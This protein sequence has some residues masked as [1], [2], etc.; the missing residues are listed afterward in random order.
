MIVVKMK[1]HHQKIADKHGVSLEQIEKELAMGEKVE[2]AEHPL[3]KMG[4]H[5]TAM[6][7]LEDDPSYYTKLKA[8]GLADELEKGCKE[9]S[10][11]RILLKAKYLKRWKGKDGKWQYKYRDDSKGA[12]VDT[13]VEVIPAD[14]FDASS[15]FDRTDDPNASVES[16]L[17]NAP[18]ETLEK[19]KETETKLKTIT[20]TVENHRTSGEGAAAVYTPERMKLHTKIIEKMF[21]PDKI[22]SALPEA[23]KSPTFTML[24]GRGGCLSF[25][26]EYLTTDGGWKKMS[27]YVE[28]ERVLIFDSE[29]NTTKFEIPEKYINLPCDT[30]YHILSRGV[31]QMVSKEHTVLHTKKFNPEK[32]RTIKAIDL[33]EE[34]TRLAG[35]W[36]GMIPCSFKAPRNVEGIL[37][38]DD[39]LRLMVAVCADGNYALETTNRCRISLRKERKK[40]RL[41]MLLRR[42]GIDYKIYY[43][44]NRPTEDRYSFD[45]PENN[46]TLSSYWKASPEQLKIISEEVIQWDGWTDKYKAW[47]FTS[48]RKEDIDFVSYLFSTQGRR[49]SFYKDDREGTGWN[50]IWRVSAGVNPGSAGIRSGGDDT[51]IFVEPSVDGR[52]YCFTVSTGFF[53]TRRNDCICITGNSGKSW[54]NGK[55]YDPEKNVVL[56]SDEIKQQL[57]EYKGWNAFEVH[58]ES[59]DILEK[60]A[61]MA[62][63]YGLNIVIDATMKTTSSAVERVLDFKKAGY[64]I[65]A[66]YMHAP[67]QVSAERAVKRFTGP[68]GRYVPVGVVLSNVSNE[69]TFDAVKQY[70]S[71]WS[72]R[73]SSGNPP[74]KLV[75]KKNGG[76]LMMKAIEVDP[77]EKQDS[78]PYDEYDFGPVVDEKDYSPDLKEMIE[79]NRP[80]KVKK[81]ILIK[82]KY[83]KRWKNRGTGKWQYKYHTTGESTKKDKT[84]G[85][86]KGELFTIDMGSGPEKVIIAK[87]FK[88][89]PDKKGYQFVSVIRHTSGYPDKIALIESSRFDSAIVKKSIM[90]KARDYKEKLKRMMVRKQN[91]IACP[92]AEYDHKYKLQGK[93]SWHGLNIAIENK[94]GSYRRGK[95][96]NGQS[97]KTYMNYDYGR[98]GGSKATDNEG[99]DIYVGPDDTAEMVYVVHQQDPFTRVYDEDKAMVNFPSR[100]S[101]IEGFLSQ[102]DRPDFLGPISEFTIPDFK[103]ALKEKRGAALYRSP[104]TFRKSKII[105]RKK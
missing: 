58:E 87:D 33:V 64:K 76:I 100:E 78:D 52:K 99:V 68:T 3:D 37:L 77:E 89:D 38:T 50:P 56:D 93:M 5:K 34:N 61:A 71:I 91:N 72:F 4:A 31:D 75:S 12:R 85:F 105:V 42:C 45:A 88:P 15:Y 57:P 1:Q 59:S 41:E 60:A 17:L 24:G 11:S 6:H 92:P 40:E 27:E 84:K 39:E 13:S 23:G 36:D 7:H 26:H 8:A 35:G 94:K 97:W 70:A 79:R 74:P 49:S 81:S 65:E 28:G 103:E 22:N 90:V 9:V 83:L 54:F 69:K 25:D 46:K 30:F 101:A 51:G 29:T 44:A 104:S 19:I 48:T 62:K 21:S 32:W 63:A 82:S 14:K 67:R 10:K 16:V 98:I 47:I 43:N 66:H 80:K 96:P 18:P 20:Q 73:D 102:Y 95:D 2:I 53:I 55:V 86:K